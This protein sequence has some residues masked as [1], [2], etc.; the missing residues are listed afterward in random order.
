MLQNS[1]LS[2]PNSIMGVLWR[3]LPLIVNDIYIFI[4]CLLIYAN[5]YQCWFLWTL[6][7]NINF[8]NPVLK[9]VHFSVSRDFNTSPVFEVLRYS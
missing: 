4:H 7:L 2:L 8:S 6:T 1:M 9:Y 5:I 3:S